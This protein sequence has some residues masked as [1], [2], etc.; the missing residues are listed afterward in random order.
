MYYSMLVTSRTVNILHYRL[1]TIYSSHFKYTQSTQY[2][3]YR[4]LVCLTWKNNSSDS[5]PLNVSAIYNPQYVQTVLDF[6]ICVF[7]HLECH[8]SSCIVDSCTKISHT[9]NF[10]T[11]YLVLYISPKEKL[12][13]VISGER[14][15][16]GIG[17][18]RKIHLFGN[19]FFRDSHC[20]PQCGGAPS[21]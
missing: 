1:P 19:V 13:G 18:S 7:Q 5:I 2:T 12:N 9:T 17:S 14:G 15:G 20:K 8:R 10:W 6:T 3:R 16:Q 11:E 4:E 21:C